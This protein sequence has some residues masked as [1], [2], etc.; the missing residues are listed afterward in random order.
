VR[1][2][3]SAQQPSYLVLND[4]YQR[5]WTAQVDGNLR[6]SSS[7]MLCFEPS[8]SSLARTRSSPVRAQSL[9]IGGVVSAVSI[10]IVLASILIGY[11]LSRR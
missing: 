6:V 9:L 8:P 3:A 11:A 4:F 5:G 7:P 10:V 1:I 2:T